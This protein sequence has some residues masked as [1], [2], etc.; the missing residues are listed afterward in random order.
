MLPAE[1][2]DPLPFFRVILSARVS[3]KLPATPGHVTIYFTFF[4]GQSQC[5]YISDATKATVQQSQ[6]NKQ[7]KSKGTLINDVTTTLT[8][9]FP[10]PS[11][12]MHN[13]CYLSSVTKV[14]TK[15][16]PS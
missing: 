16:S 13:V 6:G 10:P 9:N 8:Q 4:R 15:S 2:A 11:Y 5:N 3:A 7:S 12:V 14:T 1:M